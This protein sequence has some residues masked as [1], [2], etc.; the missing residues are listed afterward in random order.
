MLQKILQA[1][2]NAKRKSQTYA[3]ER[4]IA[5]P[6]DAAQE[7]RNDASVIKKLRL[8]LAIR[9]RSD[10]YSNEAN[11]KPVTAS[12]M[13]KTRWIVYRKPHFDKLIADICEAIRELIELFPTEK[14]R[15]QEL[16]Q[17]DLSG[18][19]PEQ[20][21]LVDEIAD[22]ADDFELQEATKVAMEA[23]GLVFAS[24]EVS[25][26]ATYNMGNQHDRIA[27]ALELQ[28]IR[29]VGSKF[30]GSSVSNFGHTIG[31]SRRDRPSATTISQPEESSE[32][33]DSE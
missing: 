24:S 6:G 3:N 13:N 16:C 25:G 23:G 1:F 28:S 14:A 20:L 17:R 30:R 29:V 4:K 10:Q 11:E 31:R 8:R 27:T 7:Q 32:A 33:S 26:R 21:E 22:D 5:E 15:V 9:T 2:D 19:E 18:L 12:F